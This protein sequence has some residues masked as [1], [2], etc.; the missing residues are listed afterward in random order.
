MFNPTPPV[1]PSPVMASPN[2]QDQVYETDQ[3]YEK[4]APTI[5]GH[6]HRWFEVIDIGIDTNNGY[7]SSIVSPLTAGATQTIHV[8]QAPDWF[9]VSTLVNSAGAQ[10]R[11]YRGPNPSGPPIRL[12]NGGHVAI[13][14]GGLPDL[15][16]TA[17][18]ANV[19]GT[20]IACAGY[21]PS[22]IDLYCASQ[23]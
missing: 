8:N 22:E 19:V 4:V 16:L 17:V 3:P 14:A 1:L 21:D 5:G 12:G 23:A 11:I 9:I 7:A 10:L 2:T 13:P 6:R 20:V 15:A 18:T